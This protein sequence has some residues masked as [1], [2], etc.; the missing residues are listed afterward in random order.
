MFP[1]PKGDLF[2]SIRLCI[3]SPTHKTKVALVRRHIREGP[4]SFSTSAQASRLSRSTSME[5]APQKPLARSPRGTCEGINILLRTESSYDSCLPSRSF[6]SL[7]TKVQVVPKVN[8]VK[9][10]AEP[11]LSVFSTRIRRAVS[12]TLQS[13]CPIRRCQFY[14]SERSLGS[15]QGGSGGARKEKQSYPFRK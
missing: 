12:F 4:Q 2:R 1:N 10:D 3:W 11:N 6:A 8:K 5:E 9:F 7:P 13:F 14:T 15:S